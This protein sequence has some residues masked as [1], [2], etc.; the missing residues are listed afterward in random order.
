MCQTQR[1]VALLEKAAGRSDLTLDERSLLDH[2]LNEQRQLLSLY[3]T[4]QALIDSRPEARRLALKL[5]L[6]RR[7]PWPAR[8]KAALAVVLPG[9][10]GT[11]LAERDR[12]SRELAGGIRL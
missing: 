9:F 3:R 12:Q 6:N 10:A 1:E 7:F 5:A 11:R 8:L 2:T 4:R